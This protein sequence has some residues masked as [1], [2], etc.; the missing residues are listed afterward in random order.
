MII[1]KSV[2]GKHPKIQLADRD[3]DTAQFG[4]DF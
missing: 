1:A 2:F 3:L 4:G